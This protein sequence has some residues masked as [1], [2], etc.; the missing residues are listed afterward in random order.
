MVD[1]VK[2]PLELDVMES[3]NGI[4]G[5]INDGAEEKFGVGTAEFLREA[6]IRQNYMREEIFRRYRMDGL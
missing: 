3:W 5:L 6:Y 1:Y 2:D 4:E